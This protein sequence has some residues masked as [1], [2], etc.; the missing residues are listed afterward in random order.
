MLLIVSLFT[1]NL[2]LI[3][4][5]HSN[6]RFVHIINMT[7]SEPVST[8]SELRGPSW[9][10][11]HG[12]W[13][14]NYLCNQYLS[15]PKLWIRIPLRRGVLDSTLYDKVC[16]W[17]VSDRLGKLHGKKQFDE[18]MRSCWS[19]LSLFQL[20]TTTVL[21]QTRCANRTSNPDTYPTKLSSNSFL[22][23]I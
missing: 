7:I 11:S 14:Y 15:T 20:T 8:Q 3:L 17:L 5:N 19:V 21:M 23:D 1:D 2:N 12:S 4:N 13:I 9:L 6:Y 10:W 18:T 16:Q 22:L